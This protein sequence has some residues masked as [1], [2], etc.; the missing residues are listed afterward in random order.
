MSAVLDSL[1]RIL[2]L[3]PEKVGP[4]LG[5]RP[6]M[7]YQNG[8]RSRLGYSMMAVELRPGTLCKR[9]FAG[10]QFSTSAARLVQRFPISNCVRRV[11]CYATQGK[12]NVH[13]VSASPNCA[14]AALEVLCLWLHLLDD[15]LRPQPQRTV[16]P[17]FER[18]D[19]EPLPA[20]Q[21]VASAAR[22]VSGVRAPA[23]PDAVFRPA[24]PSLH[25]DA[26]HRGKGLCGWRTDWRAARRFYS[27]SL[28]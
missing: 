10:N 22:F 28:Q 1:F 21:V 6:K 16:H 13:A 15:S 9:D 3:S 8:L 26:P 12:T 20:V 19:L 14:F 24:S 7:K 4:S 25:Q 23:R 17:P 27:V 2:I 18:S 11:V 5:G